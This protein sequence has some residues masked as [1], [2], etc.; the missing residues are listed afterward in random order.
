M[1]G[2]KYQITCQ[3]FKRVGL[4]YTHPARRNRA[5]FAQR[6]NGGVKI[7]KIHGSAKV[8]LI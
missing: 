2:Q 6:L 3:R 7:D 1:T 4:H 5:G 8:G